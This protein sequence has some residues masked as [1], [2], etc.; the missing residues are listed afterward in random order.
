[1]RSTFIARLFYQSQISLAD[2]DQLIAKVESTTNQQKTKSTKQAK[3]ASIGCP[4][5]PVFTK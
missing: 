5:Q 1:M 2:V 4:P 3:F